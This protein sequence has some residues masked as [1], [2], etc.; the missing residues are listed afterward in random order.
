MPEPTSRSRSTSSRTRAV[1]TGTLDG[2]QANLKAIGDG[3]AE[4]GQGAGRPDRRPPGRSSRRPTS[5][6]RAEICRGRPHAGSR[7]SRSADGKQQIQAALLGASPPA[8]RR[9][10]RR[11]TAEELN[12]TLSQGSR[13][14]S[15]LTS[16]AP[17]TRL[18]EIRDDRLLDGALHQ[19]ERLRDRHV[20]HARRDLGEHLGLSRGKLWAACGGSSFGRDQHVHDLRVD[21]RPPAPTL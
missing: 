10:S 9:R 7:A 6:F 11:S 16:S 4:D 12:T 15:L 14:T 5:A 8:T 2:V 3:L 1:T 17:T 18:P 13:L 20:D 21:R 19:H